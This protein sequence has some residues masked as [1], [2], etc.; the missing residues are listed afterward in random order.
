VK[1]ERG[2]LL[3]N[4][5][6]MEESFWPSITQ[7]SDGNVYLVTNWPSII[8]VDGLDSIRRISPSQLELTPAV[9]ASAQEY[10]TS[11]ELKRQAEKK[12][13]E[14]LIVAMRQTPPTVDGN[15]DDWADAKWVTID[16]RSKQKGDWGR[17]KQESQAA[18]AIAG[19]RLYAAFKTGEPKMLA[20]SGSAMQNLFKTGGAL[21]LML[22]T[23]PKADSKRKSAVV[24]DVRLLVSQVK[25]KT[26]AVLYRP[27][28]P[29][30]PGEP[31]SFSSPL[32]TIKF[33]R[34]EDVSTQVMLAGNAD[35]DFELSVPLSV[36][37]LKPSQGASLRGDVGLLRGNGFETVQ[38]VYWHNK[39]TGLTSD[40]P[41]EAELTPQFWG[42]WRLE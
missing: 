13:Q 14:N 35:G 2:T 10:F 11:S 33:D 17:A 23:D 25:N 9:L 37:G 6:N 3:N 19:D 39:A 22:G 40:I 15:L 32:R 31:V 42:M 8:R 20:N 36:L 41:S 16:V 29:G 4:V 18:V 30:T 26:V 27:V 5:T 21:D 28:A 1:A 38:R 34:V 7:T 24:G 12:S